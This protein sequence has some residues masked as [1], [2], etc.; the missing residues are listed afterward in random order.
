[1]A[2][3]GFS[4]R[5]SAREKALL[6]RRVVYENARRRLI[7]VPWIWYKYTYFIAYQC[8]VEAEDMGL[9]RR[10]GLVRDNRRGGV[11]PRLPEE[12]N[13]K[14][15]SKMKKLLVSVSITVVAMVSGAALAAGDAAKGKEKA[16]PCAA[17]HGPDGNSVNPDW[18]KIAGQHATY[19][20]KQI[21]DFK[22]GSR[23]DNLMTAQAAPLK[24]EDIADLAAYFSSQKASLGT[25]AADK[26]ALGE[27]I[28]RGGN[29]ETGVAACMAC[30]GPSGAGIGEAKFPAI[31]GQHAKYLAK[32]LRDFRSGA[33]ANDPNNMMRDVVARM[34]DEEIEAVAQYV[35][36]LRR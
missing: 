36:G 26:V 33:R 31:N 16:V 2:L 10:S 22:A 29:K 3:E 20:M 9:R 23:K 21:K 34:T 12:I 35:Q 15:G 25:A 7:F 24:D 13:S 5:L 11:Y 18:P 4:R 28:Y 8:Q 30:H 19:I 32:A 17:C 27:K 14:V 6:D 1:M